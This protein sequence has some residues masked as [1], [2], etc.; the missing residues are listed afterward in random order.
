M[1]SLHEGVCQRHVARQRPADHVRGTSFGAGKDRGKCWDESSYFTQTLLP[2]YIAEYSDETAEWDVVYDA[3]GHLAE[4]HV[5]N[6][7][8]LGTLEVRSYVG[9]WR[10]TDEPDDLEIDIDQLYPT[11][12]PKNRYKFAL[13]IEKEGFDAILDRSGI[14]QRYDL[15]VFSSKGMST[16]ATR[17]LVEHLSEAGVTILIAHDFDLPGLTIAY[18]L[19]HDN[20]RYQFQSEPNVIDIGLRLTDV[21]SMNLQSEP[22]TYEQNKDPRDKFRIMTKTT[23][24][25]T[26][27][28][29]FWLREGVSH[30]LWSGKRVELNAMTSDQFIAWLERKLVEAGVEK[31]VP[32]Q[33]TLAAAWKRACLIAQVKESVETLTAASEEHPPAPPADLE[34]HV[35]ELLSEC[36]LHVVGR[37]TGV[38]R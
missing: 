10:A 6:E 13:F 36:N 28:S 14:A 32:D 8:G 38:V 2:E 21:Q 27:S 26:M 19:C 20:K 12:G 34:S 30:K 3:R 7:L 4:P 37:S 24:P 29:I 11:R 15:A 5:K 35:R 33:E 9:S 31:V 23:I 17:M 1:P 18:T 25:P 16:T 22:V